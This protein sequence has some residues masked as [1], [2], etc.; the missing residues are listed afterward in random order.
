[1]S[2][3]YLDQMAKAKMLVNGLRKNAEWAEKHNIS[4]ED[5]LAMEMTIGEG[6]KLNAEVDALREKTHEIVTLANEK[7]IEVKDKMTCIKRIIKANVD[8]SRWMDYGVMDKR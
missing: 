3:T 1:M 8:P 4:Q 2:K 7:M 6:E 5:L